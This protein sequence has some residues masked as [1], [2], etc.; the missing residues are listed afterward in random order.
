MPL[1][2]ENLVPEWFSFNYATKLDY[3]RYVWAEASPNGNHEHE[4]RLK[5]E[6]LLVFTADSKDL[7]LPQILARFP[8]KWLILQSDA[9]CFGSA[10]IIYSYSEPEH[11]WNADTPS[12]IL[13]AA[14]PDRAHTNKLAP[15]AQIEWVYLPHEPVSGHQYLPLQ[16]AVSQ[17]KHPESVGYR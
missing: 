8:E 3:G 13:D 2:A 17:P 12:I 5:Y 15:A 9:M 4:Q 1:I 14:A 6:R 10:I 7:L 16:L 11:W